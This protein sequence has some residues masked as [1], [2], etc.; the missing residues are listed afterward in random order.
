MDSASARNGFAPLTNDVASKRYAIL[1]VKEL[2]KEVA[3][4]VQVYRRASYKGG[5]KR[6]AGM[7]S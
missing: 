2:I 6:G 4:Q 7:K 1:L 3:R 5:T